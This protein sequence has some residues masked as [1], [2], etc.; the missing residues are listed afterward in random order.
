M[1]RS[2]G[3][4]EDENRRLKNL[5]AK[6][7]LDVATLKDLLRKLTGLAMRRDALLRLIAECGISQA[8]TAP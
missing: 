1:R 5:L 2:W 8:T 7:M 4:L 6:S 3:R